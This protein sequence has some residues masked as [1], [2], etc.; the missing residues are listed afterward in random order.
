MHKLHNVSMKQLTQFKLNF[1]S[2]SIVT[3]IH[4]SAALQRQT[5]PFTGYLEPRLTFHL[6]LNKSIFACWNNAVIITPT[7]STETSSLWEP[8]S[9]LSLAASNVLD[10]QLIVC[11]FFPTTSKLTHSKIPQLFY[12][13]YTR[14]STPCKHPQKTNFISLLIMSISNYFKWT[15]NLWLKPISLFTSTMSSKVKKMMK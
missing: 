6:N 11:V 3:F 15:G 2:L 14:N 4:S 12:N 13:V 8:H 7:N 5:M 1:F 10:V 9:F